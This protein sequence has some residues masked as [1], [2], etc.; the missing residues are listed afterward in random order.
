MAPTTTADSRPDWLG[1]LGAPGEAEEGVTVR[2]ADGSTERV[3]VD[4][5][6]RMVYARTCDIARL[7]TEEGGHY[8]PGQFGPTG[9]AYI[10]P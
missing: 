8:G 9:F 1:T 5:A 6:N 7:A 4:Q 2:A 3:W 10:C